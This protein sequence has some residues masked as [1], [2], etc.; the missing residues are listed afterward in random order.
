[1]SFFSTF[2][3]ERLKGIS[4][5]ATTVYV[6]VV[7]ESLVPSDSLEICFSFWTRLF[8]WKYVERIFF[9]RL[10]WKRK[11]QINGIFFLT[12][13]SPC[14]YLIGEKKEGIKIP[15]MNLNYLV[16]FSYIGFLTPIITDFGFVLYWI[17]G[18]NLFFFRMIFYWELLEFAIFQYKMF[19]KTGI[20]CKT[21]TLAFH[22]FLMALVK[23]IWISLT[24]YF[25]S[26]LV[27]LLYGTISIFFCWILST[28]TG[29]WLYNY[30][31][32]F[33]HFFHDNIM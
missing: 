7:G 6:V 1:M 16:I 17:A 2:F 10:C 32:N 33:L 26:K 11:S 12:F 19:S 8:L 9:F 27:L 21:T 20:L 31:S 24:A 15:S 29:I 23:E 30:V 5:T 22:F 14:F 3:R 25:F 28:V 13:F 18:Q 4:R